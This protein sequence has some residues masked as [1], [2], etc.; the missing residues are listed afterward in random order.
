[1]RIPQIPGASPDVTVTA[2]EYG[3]LVLR[4]G[5]GDGEGGRGLAASDSSAGGGEGRGELD[6]EQARLVYLD[7]QV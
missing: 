5:R 6:A 3:G 4:G 7:G 1:M 2:C